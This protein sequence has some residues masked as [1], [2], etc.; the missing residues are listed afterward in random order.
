MNKR[1]IAIAI[2]ALLV[3][4]PAV[5]Y[6][7][8]SGD[9][10]LLLRI[11]GTVTVDADETVETLV[12]LDGDA[13]VR[14]TVDDVVVVSGDITLDDATVRNLTVVSGEVSLTGSTL[15][16]ED[17]HL[18]D[19]N[20]NQGVD[21]RIAGSV[22]EGGEVGF[23]IALG[24]I[25][26]LLYIGLS[27]AIVV[28]AFAIAAVAGR[29]SNAAGLAITSDTGAVALAALVLWVT[30]PIVAVLAFITVIGIPTGLMIVAMILPAL[31]IV[32]YAVAGMRLGTWIL[33]RGR[34][35]ETPDHPYLAAFIGVGLLQ[36][37]GWIPVLGFLVATLAGLAGTGAIA[38]LVWRGFRGG[39]T[40]ATPEV[41]PTVEAAPTA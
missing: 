5:A 12:V 9:D 39:D 37:V 14:G 7:Q 32:G 1:L 27:V 35:D 17:L 20:L 21:A 13:T 19:G 4:T 36:L 38:L 18:V 31:A 25:S 30:V 29:Q 16:S 10:G 2:A 41:T 34:P 24:V 33:Y 3:L 23:G 40:P 26:V 11:G 28:L 15:I 22:Y 6:A 8:T